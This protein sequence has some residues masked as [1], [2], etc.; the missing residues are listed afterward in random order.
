[1]TF[2]QRNETDLKKKKNLPEAFSPEGS[3]RLILSSWRGQKSKNPLYQ[4][5]IITQLHDLST[6]KNH[7]FFLITGLSMYAKRGCLDN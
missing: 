5:E 7:L 6:R 1:M 4:R 2:T 3:L